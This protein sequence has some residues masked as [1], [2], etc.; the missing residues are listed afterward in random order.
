MTDSINVSLSLKSVKTTSSSMYGAQSAAANGQPRIPAMANQKMPCEVL[1]P[2]RQ[3]MNE[4]APSMHMYMAKLEGR[5]AVLAWKFPGLMTVAMRKK[6]P[7]LP[8][9]VELTTLNMTVWQ[10]AQTKAR[11]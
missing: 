6:M 3:F 11:P 4:A 9:R 5:N 1:R 7:I 10:R 8:F 2:P